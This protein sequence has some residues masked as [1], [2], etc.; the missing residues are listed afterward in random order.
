ML[1]RQW[2]LNQYKPGGSVNEMNMVQG[3]LR[4]VDSPRLSSAT[5]WWVFANPALYEVFRMNF[6]NG[7]QTPSVDV[8]NDGDPLSRRTQY[9]LPGCGCAAVDSFG[10]YYNPGA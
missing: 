5:G 10:V 4:P 3:L 6:Y 1:A 8:I 9:T 7:Q 2:F